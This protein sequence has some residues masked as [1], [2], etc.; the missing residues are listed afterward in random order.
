MILWCNNIQTALQ[1]IKQ[2][3]SHNIFNTII[4]DNIK[5]VATKYTKVDTYMLSQASPVIYKVLLNSQPTSLVA[6]SSE[7][8]VPWFTRYYPLVSQPHS[9]L[10][11]PTLNIALISSVTNIFC[12]P[13]HNTTQLFQLLDQGFR[14]CNFCPLCQ[15]SYVGLG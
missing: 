8:I 6:R 15:F 14:K 9:L 4:S 7:S 2:D 3:Q 1:K 10:A 12:I 11:L 5:N 13:N